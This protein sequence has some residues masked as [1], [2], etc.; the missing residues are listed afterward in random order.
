[1]SIAQNIAEIQKKID[2]TKVK[3]VAVTKNHS[4]SAMLEALASGITAVG[5]NRVQEML[6]KH[7]EIQSAGKLA[8]WHLIGHLQTNKVRQAV[9]LA[10][11]IHSVD[12]E[13]LAIEIDKV[14]GKLGKR[15]DVLLQ[16]NI[17]DE[18]SKSGVAVGQALPLANLISQLEHVRL[19]G[20]MTIAPFSEN[21]ETVRP[22]FNEMY[23][24]F[25]ELNT[26]KLANTE[27]TW[28]SMGMTNDYMVAIEE[29]S[30]LVRIGT[31]IFGSRQY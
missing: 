22:V 8:E 25:S 16:V 28:L 6:A 30:N 1:M 2:L 13:R 17:A 20:L 10:D 7:P 9:P 19:C 12:S 18:D 24:L 11:L 14:A 23:Q 21:P 26:I 31:G 15:Q 5:E 27:I 29:G 4:T 3:L